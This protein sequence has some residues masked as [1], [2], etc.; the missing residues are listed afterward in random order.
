MYDIP[1]FIKRK[2]NR[3]KEVKII[4]LFSYILHFSYILFVCFVFSSIYTPC[5][6]FFCFAGWKTM[7]HP[8]EKYVMDKLEN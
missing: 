3:K 7:L 6:F 8:S 1:M 4:L 2:L 5:F